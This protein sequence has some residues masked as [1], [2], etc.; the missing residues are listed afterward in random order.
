MPILSIKPKAKKF[1][2]SLPPK[3]QRQVKNHILALQDNPMP[4][5]AKK[6]LGYENYTRTDI[7]EYRIIYQ[8]KPSNNSLTVVLVGRRNDDSI[9]RID[10]RTLK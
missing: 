3:H 9:Y 7:G 5:D 1:I 10:K 4:H 2:Q 6:L 8:L